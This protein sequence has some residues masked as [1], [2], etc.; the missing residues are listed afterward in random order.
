MT[1][2]LI[3]LGVA[4]FIALAVPVVIT[5]ISIRGLSNPTVKPLSSEEKKQY[6]CSQ[7]AQANS[8]GF[9][10]NFAMKVGIA[11]SSMA[12]WRR[13]DRPTFFCR[14]LVQA[15]NKKQTSF[16]FVTMF[17]DEIMLTT[18]D[19]ADSQMMPQPPGYYSQSFSPVNQDEQWNQHLQMENYLMDT[20]GA[21]LVQNDKPFEECFVDAIRRQVNFISSI[22]LWPLRGIYWFYVR[23]Q[24]WH[25]QS[26][27]AQHDKGM[28]RLPNE[29][30]NSGN[31][32]EAA[33]T[34]DINDSEQPEVPEQVSRSEQPEQPEKLSQS[35]QPEESE[36]AEE[37]TTSI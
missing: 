14:Y 32:S 27:Q 35:E 5:F 7:W 15:G 18:N 3:V 33:S 28:I 25:N 2:L 30:S 31:M 12:I 17:E 20:G 22:S 37:V 6:P 29:L 8:F 26:I 10:G 4:A 16:D 9:V 13:S 34:G 23:R 11:D 1:I 36:Q 19:K 24:M 21:T